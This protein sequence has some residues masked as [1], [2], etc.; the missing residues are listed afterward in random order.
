MTT[1]EMMKEVRQYC[2][3]LLVNSKNEDWHNYGYSKDNMFCQMSKPKYSEDYYFTVCI[4]EDNKFHNEINAVTFKKYPWYKL[5]K[6]K[7]RKLIR[8]KYKEIIKYFNNK[9][10]YDTAL[11]TYKLL[12]ISEIRKNKLKSLDK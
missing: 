6:L 11:L 2:L 8:N 10:A 3:K 12:P 9:K 7:E 4:Y 1:Q 5:I